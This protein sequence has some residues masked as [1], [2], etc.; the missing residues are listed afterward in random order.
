MADETAWIDG[1]YTFQL[2]KPIQNA[3]GEQIKELTF[4]EPTGGDMIEAGN[5]VIFNAFGEETTVSFNEKKL[6]AMISRLS[7]Q[8]PS[9]IKN[10][11]PKD[12]ID[13]GWL[14]ASFFMPI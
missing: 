8:P 12:F 6:G 3:A 2:R 4:R 9:T 7:N 10:M 13:V 5:P 14:L 11:S 1:K